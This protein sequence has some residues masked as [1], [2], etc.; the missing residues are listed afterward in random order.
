MSSRED[1]RA[2]IR[3]RSRG[4]RGAWASARVVAQR[5]KTR[6]P[7][8]IP[9]Q[10][11]TLPVRCIV[12]SKDRPMQLDAC[13]RSIERFARYGGPVAVLYAASTPDFAEAYRMVAARAKAEFVS[14][15]QDFRRDVLELVDAGREHTVFHTDDDVFY[16]Q[17][18]PIPLPADHVACFSLR[19]GQ[20]TT[21]AYPVGRRQAVPDFIREG[22]VVAWDW[23]AP[24]TTLPT[25][26][27]STA[28]SFQR[29][30]FASCSPHPLHQSQRARG[31]ARPEAPPSAVVG[32]CR[33]GT[34]ALCRSR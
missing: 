11:P 9:E 14:Q 29:G 26:C 24:N 17:V 18:T 23:T 6:V 4:A 30:C 20:N 28:T 3:A 25:H 22:E 2:R 12:F 31:G 34:A 19:L 13:L 5:R 15:S 16:R 27:R 21:Y 10:A 7:L 8:T 33:S 32:C 1:L